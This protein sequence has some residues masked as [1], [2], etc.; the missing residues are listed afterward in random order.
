MCIAPS[1]CAVCAALCAVLSTTGHAHDSR[2]GRRRHKRCVE[3]RRV[4]AVA[5]TLLTEESGYDLHRH[6][7]AGLQGGSAYIVIHTVTDARIMSTD[8]Y[9]EIPRLATKR[10][11]PIPLTACNGRNGRHTSTTPKCF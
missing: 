1:L 10:D 6:S 2:K 4:Q 3:D 5:G 11:Q 9:A 7:H 8:T